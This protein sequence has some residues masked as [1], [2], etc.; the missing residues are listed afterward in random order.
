[1][2]QYSTSHLKTR[3]NCDVIVYMYLS[4]RERKE[5][6]EER[7]GLLFEA[8]YDPLQLQDIIL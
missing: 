7:R 6:R 3:R 8:T 5:E 4:Y 1:M 2:L